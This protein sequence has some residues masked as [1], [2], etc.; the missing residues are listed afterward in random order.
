M[1]EGGG[2][3]VDQWSERGLKI[4]VMDRRSMYAMASP[5]ISVLDEVAAHA[6]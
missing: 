2:T 3:R 6:R 5:T 4:G 1:V